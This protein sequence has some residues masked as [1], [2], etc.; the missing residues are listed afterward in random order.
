LRHQFGPQSLQI[1]VRYLTAATLFSL[2]L[3]STQL[4]FPPVRAASAS[5]IISEFRTRGPNGVNDE[6]IELYNFSASPVDIGNW[7][8]RASNG[9]GTT[10]RRANVP[11]GTILQPGAHYLVTNQFTTGGPY[12]G[13][14][15]GDQ[16]YDAD[17]NGINDEGGVAITL[18]DGTTV[19]DQVGL[20]AGS[21]FKEGNP[22]V[23]PAP[24]GTNLNGEFS[25]VRKLTSG[26]PQDTDDNAADFI[27]VSVDG[28]TYGGRASLL[29][30][31]GP[32][33]RSSPIEHNATIN[34]M[35]L[36]ASAQTAQPPN[37]VRKQCADPTV[38]ECNPNRSNFGTLS[39]R[40]RVVNNTGSP[41][42]RLRFRIVNFTTF[43][44]PDNATADL[45]ALTAS[46]IT[47]MVN[48]PAQCGGSPTCTVTAHGTTLEQ[49]PNQPVGGG[50][51]STLSAGTVTLAE[52]LADGASLNVQFLLGVQQTGNFRFLLNV[53][54]LP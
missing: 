45:R 2:I 8:I 19:V 44:R 43:P 49:P 10:A 11:S 37:R 20:S 41:V 22:L 27:F 39:I 33:N 25:F 6:F 9:A 51:N 4:C 12:S 30:A 15:A 28:G 38:E 14:V 53:E 52:P 36:D 21:A 54:A 29:G 40:R 46:D 18:P 35:L 16:T 48:D 23:N 13:P 24:S 17:A 3:F 42:T 26:V 5:I 47:V 7:K 34:L 1:S 31:P 50:W 32:E